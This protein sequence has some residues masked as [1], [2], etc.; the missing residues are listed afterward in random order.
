MNIFLAFLLAANPLPDS[1]SLSSANASYDGNALVLK[2]QVVLDHGFGKMQADEAVLERQ[3]TGKD[4]PFSFIHLQKGVHLF[5]KNSA[6]LKCDT[7][8]LDFVSLKGNLNSKDKVVYTDSIKRKKGPNISY[9]LAGKVAELQ[10][11]KKSEADQKSQYEIDT[12]ITK[13]SVQIDYA[14]NFILHADH[15]VYSKGISVSAR[16][17]EGNLC[18]LTHETDLVDA[19]TMDLDLVH[20][21][22]T[23]LHPKGVIYDMKFISDALAWDHL[24]NTVTLKG[25]VELNDPAL[26]T[27]FSED[28]LQLTQNNQKKLSSI[29][30]KGKTTLQYLNSHRLVSHGTLYL[31]R[32][33]LQADIESPQTNGA[34]PEGLQLY[35]EEGE[36]AL[37]A[38]KANVEYSEAFLPVSISLKGHVRLFSHDSKQPGR[39]GLADR[40]TY[41][42]TTRTFILGAD[43]GKKVLFVNQEDNLRISAQEVHVTEDPNTRKQTVKGIG[44]VQLAFTVEE[45]ALM[46]KFFKL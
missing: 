30:T 8:D 34:V 23:M 36:V 13:E 15:A 43:P 11:S 20:Y 25:K 24:K 5:L 2:G 29:R 18:H 22:L 19:D 21:K 42:P 41:L 3:E 26:G 17:K 28:E 14:D 38:D 35:Y 45:Q 46:N 27:L 44:N 1:G 10:M 12:L 33:Y 32:D 39:Y 9:R 16:A 37:F 4:F 31:D 7:A 6:E 40:V